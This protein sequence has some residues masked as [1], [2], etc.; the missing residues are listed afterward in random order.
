M[1]HRLG[2]RSLESIGYSQ[3]STRC[4]GPS[5]A[6]DDPE[7]EASQPIGSGGAVDQTQ[8]GIIVTAA[9]FDVEMSSR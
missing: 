2:D 9:L 8:A 5:I 4:T 3:Y 7:R 6:A 1:D